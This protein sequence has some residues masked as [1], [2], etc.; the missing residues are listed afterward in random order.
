MMEG[1]NNRERLALNSISGEDGLEVEPLHIIPTIYYTNHS[2]TGFGVPKALEG[3]AIRGVRRSCCRY[4][5]LG[6]WP[7]RNEG[8]SIDQYR[9]KF[10]CSH[11][12]GR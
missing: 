11:D 8:L 9:E 1:L 10:E 12:K 4:W 3:E 7:Q 6:L 5:D 2:C